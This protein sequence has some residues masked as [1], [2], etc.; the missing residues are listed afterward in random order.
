MY[1][2]TTKLLAAKSTVKAWHN[3]D[4]DDINVQ[5]NEDKTEIN[6]L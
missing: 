4:Y 1:L 6:D 3:M 5:I 2:F